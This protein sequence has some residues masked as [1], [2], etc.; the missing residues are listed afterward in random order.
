MEYAWYTSNAY[1]THY[2]QISTKFSSLDIYIRGSITT[3]GGESYFLLDL[4]I[5]GKDLSCNHRPC[6]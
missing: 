3:S 5:V 1:T 6:I 4:A 2:F